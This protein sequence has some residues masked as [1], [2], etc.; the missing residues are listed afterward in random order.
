[1]QVIALIAVIAPMMLVVIVSDQVGGTITGAIVF[2]VGVLAIGF[3]C[4]IVALLARLG[5]GGVPGS[6]RGI[7]PFTILLWGIGA[8]VFGAAWAWIAYPHV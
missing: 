2:V 7:R 3:R 4:R 5:L 6:S 8:L 1:V